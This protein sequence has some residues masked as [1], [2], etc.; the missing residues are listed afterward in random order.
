MRG[1]LGKEPREAAAEAI[2]REA[3][4]RSERKVPYT[5]EEA[6]VSVSQINQPFGSL[7]PGLVDWAWGLAGNRVEV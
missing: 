6:C 1:F 4:G 3:A 7:S 2:P 5:L